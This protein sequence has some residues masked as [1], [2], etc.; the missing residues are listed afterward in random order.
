MSRT[1]CAGAFLFLYAGWA[2]ADNWPAWRGA[3]AD[4]TTQ[5]TN[6]PLNWSA[7]ENVRWKVKLPD[8]GNSTPV[9]WGDRIFLTQAIEKKKLRTLMCLHRRDGKLLWQKEVEYKEKEHTHN[10]NPYCSASPATDGERVVVSHG[11][12][13][14]FCYDFEG[15]ELW[16]RDLGK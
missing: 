7:T 6:L 4:G 12:A 5:E 3:N 11:S 1:L 15:K 2:S 14:V 9:I 13:G 16:R 8:R 10:T